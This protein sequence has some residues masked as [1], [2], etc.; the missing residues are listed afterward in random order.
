MNWLTKEQ[1]ATK[2]L[3]YLFTQCEPIE[4]RSLAPLQDTPSIKA[5]YSAN[6]TVVDPYIVKMSAHEYD[7]I[8]NADK[9]TT[10]RFHQDI[11]IPSYLLAIAV[12]NLAVKEVGPR[13]SIIAEPGADYLDR[14]ANELKNLSGLLDMTEEYLTPY[15]WGNY[16]LLVLPP[17]FP[18]GG[19][20]NPLL[21]FAS[22]TIIVGDGSQVYV[23]THEI[24][25]SWTGN[26]VTCR[27][28]S[29]MWLNEGFTVFEERKVSE[30]VHGTEFAKIE[31]QLGNVSLW[32]D[33][34]GFG[35]TS[36]FSSLYPILTDASPDDSFSEVPYE[37]GFQ[38]V[39]FIE[40][41]FKTKDDFRDMLRTYILSHS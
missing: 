31:A 23:A 30:R 9:T 13:A 15:I 7:A 16:A 11:K 20:E 6:V 37:K 26:E 5:P 10:Y 19:M 1:T 2:V 28:W 14:Y 12:G 17:S 8:K 39:T 35:L 22:P 18:Y 4:C 34:N 24:A 25:H 36:N 27:D 38:F 21:T 32:D 41:L 33:M 3:Q 40:S 29:N